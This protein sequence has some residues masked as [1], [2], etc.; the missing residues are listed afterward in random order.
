MEIKMQNRPIDAHVFR[1]IADLSNPTKPDHHV[2]NVEFYGTTVEELCENF[3]SFLKAC[4]YS[5]PEG[6][7]I[8]YEY[9]DIPKEEL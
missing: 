6:A 7:H 9:E 4:G 3:E 1:F 5:L 2:V 8:G